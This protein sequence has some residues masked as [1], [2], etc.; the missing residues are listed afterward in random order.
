MRLYLRLE[1][2]HISAMVYGLLNSSGKEYTR[3]RCFTVMNLALVGGEE[4]ADGFEDVHEALLRPLA[5]GKSRGV[6]L[7]TC[8]AH[9]GLAV[10]KSWCQ[11]ACDRLLP[12]VAQVDTPLI[13]DKASASDP[14][15]VALLTESDWIYIGGGFPNTGMT[16]LDD[17]PAMTALR[18]A[19]ER[20]ALII[21]ASA[22]A[23]MMCTRAVMITSGTRAGEQPT[24]FN[25]LNWVPN[26]LCLPHFNK[27]YAK[28]WLDHR[29]NF[30]SLTLLGIDEQTALVKLNGNW[31]TLGHGAVTIISPEGDSKRYT[32]GQHVTL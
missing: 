27:S 8:A 22:G 23:M 5:N 11:R 1:L 16:I 4:F 3:K 15:N 25:A 31:Q 17:T 26:A 9:D 28:R 14:A 13:V 19:A 20:G 30:E 6:Y 21:G 2:C 10:V 32:S 12:Y 7:P 18:Q 24:L 29:P